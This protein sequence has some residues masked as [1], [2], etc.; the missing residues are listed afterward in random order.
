MSNYCRRCGAELPSMG[1]FCRK[2]GALVEVVAPSAPVLQNSNNRAQWAITV[3]IAVAAC[4]AGWYLWQGKDAK[5]AETESSVVASNATTPSSSAGAAMQ[6]TE[7]PPVNPVSTPNM[8]TKSNEAMPSDLGLGGVCIGY[9]KG[10]V[11]ALFGKEQKITDPNKNG[12]R[13]YFY[14]DIEVI[15]TNGVVTGFISS[16]ANVSTK[17]G[18]HEGSTLQ[19][20]LRAYGDSASKFTYGDATMYEYPFKSIDQKNCLLRFAIKNDRVDYISARVA[21]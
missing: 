16:T 21:D 1:R 17:R 2:C 9:K 5:P 13:H 3:L 18:I 11:L 20:V 4:G 15:I 7:A 12:H 10:D 8:G 14:T 19:E 6:V